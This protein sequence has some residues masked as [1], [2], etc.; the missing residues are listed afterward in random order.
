MSKT[1]WIIVGALGVLYVGLQIPILYWGNSAA[2]PAAQVIVAL[3]A[4]WLAL[5]GSREL[6]ERILH[7]LICGAV[8]AIVGLVAGMIGMIYLYPESNL[9]PI[10]AF[11]F[12][13]PAGFVLGC[14]GGFIWHLATGKSLVKL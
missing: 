3:L 6:R 13:A 2:W 11:I 9:A 4:V 14:I 8:A 12:I 1:A 10:L 5:R 7:S